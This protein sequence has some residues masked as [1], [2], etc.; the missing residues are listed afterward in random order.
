MN[1][2]GSITALITAAGS[3]IGLANKSSS[4]EA[5]Q[6]I[7]GLQ[8][9]LADVQ[10]TF[11]ELFQDNQNLQN[12]KDE[13][14]RLQEEIGAETMYPFRE[15]VSW[16]K[17]DDGDDGPFCPT[18]FAKEK[19]LMPLRFR[20]RMAT[21]GVFSFG[22]PQ[23][24]VPEPGMGREPSYLIQESSIKKGRYTYPD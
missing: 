14:R 6:K 2:L 23:A 7:L 16:K 13:N 18:C 12:L 24:H 3:V 21:L 8:K 19:L 17:G 10:Q 15:S 11:A 20:S 5:N 1:D 9:R 22:C 4:V